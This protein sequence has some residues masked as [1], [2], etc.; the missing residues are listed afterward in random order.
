MIFLGVRAEDGCVLKAVSVPHHF[1]TSHFSNYT[2][3]G[4]K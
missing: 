2:I 3:L 4:G 1:L